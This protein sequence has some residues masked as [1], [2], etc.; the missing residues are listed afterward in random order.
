MREPMKKKSISIRE[1]G[2]ILGLSKTEAYWLVKKNFFAVALIGGKMRVMVDSFETW[3]ANQVWYKKV[4]GELPGKELRNISY[5]MDELGFLLGLKKDA[6]Y[7]L[8]NKGYFDTVNSICGQRRITKK[9]FDEW[10]ASQDTYR[11]IDD[12][13]KDAAIVEKTYTLP[14]IAKLLGVHRNTVYYLVEKNTF[15]IV[16]AGKQKRVVREEF[17][18]WY[19]NQDRY[20]LNIER[21]ETEGR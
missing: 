5:S 7:A 12:Q 13:A 9:S 19:Q 1:M 21:A 14:E 17:M 3:Y 2:E 10:Y 4:N 15:N 6:V 18:W 8:V 11:T 16:K 20:K